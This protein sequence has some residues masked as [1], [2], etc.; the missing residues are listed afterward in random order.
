MARP[1]GS[2]MSPERRALLLV[3]LSLSA[4]LVQ[5]QTDTRFDPGCELPF[6]EI[7]VEREIDG[8]CGAAGSSPDPRVQAQ[9][10]M[11]NNFC[12]EG[13]PTLL[14]KKHF[15][16]MQWLAEGA[17]VTRGKGKEPLDR[18]PLVDLYT[19]ARGTV[20]EGSLVQ[21]AALIDEVLYLSQKAVESVNC[22]SE[23]NSWR[24]I[25]VEL[26]EWPNPRD[27]A[28]VTAEISPHFRPDSWTPDNLEKVR[29]AGKAVRLTGQLFYDSSHIATGYRTSS[30]EIHPVYQ[31]EVC[32]SDDLAACRAGRDGTTWTNLHVWLQEID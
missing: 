32:S 24:D 27:G 2:R 26:G 21:H 28:R 30:W 15:Q 23:K 20:G 16:K 8:K 25:H 5:A 6:S 14:L 12:A 31:I 11:K 22:E 29:V 3:A 1:I 9:N 10:R 4:A 18:S 19:F 7:A 13:E 17:G